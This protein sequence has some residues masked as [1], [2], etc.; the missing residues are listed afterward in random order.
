M[1]ALA[2]KNMCMAGV[3]FEEA[4]LLSDKEGAISSEMV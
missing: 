1:Q 2:V 3:F 4:S